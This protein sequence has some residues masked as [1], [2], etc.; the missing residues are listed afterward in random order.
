MVA[1]VRIALNGIVVGIRMKVDQVRWIADSGRRSRGF[2]DDNR[3]SS[4]RDSSATSADSLYSTMIIYY[5]FW[6]TLYV[7]KY[8]EI[9]QH[10][11]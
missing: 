9:I 7:D 4:A 8:T 3:N 1:R 5:G 11:W 10:L 6:S 2:A